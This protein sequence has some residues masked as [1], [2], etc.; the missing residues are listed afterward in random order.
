[1][2]KGLALMKLRWGIVLAMLVFMAVSGCSTYRR[3]GETALERR[4]RHSH[5]LRTN[6][7]MM[8]DDIDKYLMLDDA[9]TLSNR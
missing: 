8:C 7:R 1:M 4:V 9:S 3:P 5:L 6:Y 2:R